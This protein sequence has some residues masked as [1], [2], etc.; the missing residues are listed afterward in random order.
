MAEDTRIIPVNT[1]VYNIPID[2]HAY[3]RNIGSL[4]GQHLE[5][6]LGITKFNGGRRPLH[7]SMTIVV[8]QFCQFNN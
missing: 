3:G 2:V 5:Q 7:P 4:S 1:K 6:S 8:F